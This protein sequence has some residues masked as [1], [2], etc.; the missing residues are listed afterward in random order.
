MPK[1]PKTPEVP[2]PKF[3]G[4]MAVDAQAAAL[5]YGVRLAAGDRPDLAGAAVEYVVRQ[6][7]LPGVEVPRDAVVTVWFDFGEGEGG[8]GAGVRVPREPGPRG[9]GLRRE[10][11]EPAESFSPCP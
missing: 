10:L 6:Y 4:L 2:V 1:T 7:P 8:G 9:G 11:P 5:A 3:V